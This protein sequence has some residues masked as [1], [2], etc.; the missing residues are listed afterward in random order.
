MCLLEFKMI[1]LHSCTFPEKCVYETCLNCMHDCKV[2]ILLQVVKYEKILSLCLVK[3]SSVPE[4]MFFVRVL[5][6]V[7][8][9]S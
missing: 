1:P 3:Y 9:F 6:H 4:N 5:D 7:E 2:I 8:L